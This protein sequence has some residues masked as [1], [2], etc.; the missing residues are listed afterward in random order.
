MPLEH[1][2]NEKF[3]LG[4]ENLIF[5]INKFLSLSPIQILT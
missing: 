4:G 1:T 5:W 2:K 3:A